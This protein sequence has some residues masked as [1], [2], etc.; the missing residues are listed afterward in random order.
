M[1]DPTSLDFNTFRQTDSGGTATTSKT[2]VFPCVLL[3]IGLV[4]ITLGL[5]HHMN[6]LY[7]SSNN[8]K[9]L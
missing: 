7:L 4:G 2:F 9:R 1:I 3:I 8:E 6:K 5:T